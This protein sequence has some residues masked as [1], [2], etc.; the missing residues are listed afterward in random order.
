MSTRPPGSY[1][2]SRGWGSGGIRCTDTT[3]PWAL[4]N[5]R[6]TAS[7]RRGVLRKG[8]SV[9]GRQSSAG[10][11]RRWADAVDQVPGDHVVATRVGAQ[12]VHAVPALVHRD[13]PGA[14]T[15]RGGHLDGAGERRG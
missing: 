9:S 3:G 7:R 5:S 14:V 6:M 8:Y 13:Q 11:T 4:A 15:E 10:E 12:Q 1:S 2:S